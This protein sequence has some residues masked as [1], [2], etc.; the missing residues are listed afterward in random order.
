MIIH[1]EIVDDGIFLVV[2]TYHK[3][4]Y[5][6]FNSYYMVFGLTIK[7]PLVGVLRVYENVRHKLVVE[8]L[9][10]TGAGL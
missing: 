3:L 8:E 6:M 4:I 9:E 5:I 10:S 1:T 7:Q 2:Y